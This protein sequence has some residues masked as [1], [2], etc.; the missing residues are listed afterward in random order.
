MNDP[1]ADIRRDMLPQMPAEL[2]DRVAA[3]ETVWDTDQLREEFEV[4]GFSAPLVV[5]RRKSDDAMGSLKFTHSPRYYF[6]WQA[7]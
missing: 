1:T 5:V 3:G 7:S 2:A 6:D 4:L